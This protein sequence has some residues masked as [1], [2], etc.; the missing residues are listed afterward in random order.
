MYVRDPSILTPVFMIHDT[1]DGTPVS[2][3]PQQFNPVLKTGA[4]LVSGHEP[5]CRWEENSAGRR[6]MVIHSGLVL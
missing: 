3:N 5:F 2:N 4:S 6:E 1:F